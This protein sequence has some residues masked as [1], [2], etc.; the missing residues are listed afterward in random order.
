[1][2]NLFEIQPAKIGVTAQHIIGHKGFLSE[3]R[4][5]AMD[6]RDMNFNVVLGPHS[7][8]PKD[9]VIGRQSSRVLPVELRCTTMVGRSSDRPEEESVRKR[10]S[11]TSVLIERGG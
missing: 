3:N 10:S 11:K 7:I 6:R 4:S 9:T 2:S 5:L 1:M 8:S